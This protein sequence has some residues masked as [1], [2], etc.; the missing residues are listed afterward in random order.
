MATALVTG[1]TGFIGSRVVAQ[2]RSSG[3]SVI[4]AGRR[5]VDGPR[6]VRFDLDSVDP[7]ICDGADALVHCALIPFTEPGAEERN[8]AGS[9][10]LW[11]AADRAGVSR[12]VFLSSLAAVT[13]QA[14]QYARCKRAIEDEWTDAVRLR[15][16]LVVGDG[17]LF[18][19]IV[20]FA[21]RF[22]VV[23]FVDGGEQPVYTV[24]VDDLAAVVEAALH[25]APGVVTVAHPMPTPFRDV[26]RETFARLGIRASGVPVSGTLLAAGLRGLALAGL[27]PPIGEETVHGIR[28]LRRADPAPELRP[29][30]VELRSLAESL[31]EMA[32]A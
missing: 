30:G 24:W 12:R 13:P 23:P 18:G 9:S 22:H 15:A 3:W 16:G 31:D 29:F 25:S 4:A 27:R 7:G 17:G 2:L 20:R 1:A 32:S 21:R 11:T 6:F 8:R 14:S 19:R 10:A 5:P 28:A 26:W